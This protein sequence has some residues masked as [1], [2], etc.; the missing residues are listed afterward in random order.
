LLGAIGFRFYVQLVGEANA[1]LGVLGGVIIA[2]TWLY[3]QTL[4][5]LYGAELNAVLHEHRSVPTSV[6]ARRQSSSIEPPS[7]S[8]GATAAGT[9]LVGAAFVKLLR[10]R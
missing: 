4:A 3:L 2:L 9:A 1:A 5:V 8:A 7:P 6:A 10:R